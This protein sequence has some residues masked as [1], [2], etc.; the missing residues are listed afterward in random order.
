MSEEKRSGEPH[1]GEFPV[2]T[3]GI[4]ILVDVVESVAG[5]ERT[6]PAPAMEAHTH[7]DSDELI[8]LEESAQTTLPEPELDSIVHDAGDELIL[9]EEAEQTMLAESDERPPT[10]TGA[11]ARE[12]LIAEISDQLTEEILGKIRPL[13]RKRVRRALRR[14][15]AALADS[16]EPQAER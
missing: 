5:G 16:R 4:P 11:E 2:D 13:L 15:D 14:Y 6:S 9:L 1:Q 3:L 7:D 10:S 8:L 12:A